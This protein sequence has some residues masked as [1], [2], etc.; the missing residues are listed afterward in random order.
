MARR[1]LLAGVSEAEAFVLR[2]GDVTVVGEAI[3]CGS[4]EPFAAE[5]I[6]PL[7]EGKVL[8]HDQTLPLVGRAKHVTKQFGHYLSGRNIAQFIED[9]QVEVLDL[10]EE[11]QEC[12]PPWLP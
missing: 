11:S 6:G 4:S 5:H 8:R 1:C 12:F 7:F 3:E 2:L 9:E 10:L